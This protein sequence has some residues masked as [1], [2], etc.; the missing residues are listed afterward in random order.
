MA[1][2]DVVLARNVRHERTFRI[3]ASEADA[4]VNKAFDIVEA[5][6]EGDF[7]GG[8]WEATVLSPSVRDV[9]R[10]LKEDDVTWVLRDDR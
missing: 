8:G 1:T 10:I 9:T 4:A 6:S 2:F 7:S 3:E 5:E